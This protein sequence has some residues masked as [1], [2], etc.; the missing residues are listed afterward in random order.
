MIVKNGDYKNGYLFAHDSKDV[1]F[2]EILE[3]YPKLNCVICNDKTTRNFRTH[4]DFGPIKKLPLTINNKL[5]DGVF[6]INGC[7]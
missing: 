3:S 7:Y 4:D 6:F 2:Q 5:V 1:E